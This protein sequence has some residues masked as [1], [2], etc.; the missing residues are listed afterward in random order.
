MN[1]IKNLLKILPDKLYLQLMYF[2]HFRKFINFNN[3]KSFNEKI[4]YLKLKYR[5]NELTEMADKYKVKQYISQLIGN[6]YVIPTLGVWNTTEE[7][8]FNELPEKFVLKCNNDSGG[9]VICKDKQALNIEET[10]K[11]L[12][13]RLNNNGFWYGR[14]WPYKNIKPC[15]IAEKYMEN[16][17]QNELIDYKFFCFNGQPKVVLVCSERFASKNMCKTY[18]DENWNLLDITEANHR[19][20]KE[21]KKPQNFE[22][23]KTISQKLAKDMP[24]VRIDFYEI[25]GRLYFG[26][27]TFFPASGL[28]KFKPEKW[29]NIFGDMI[30]ISKYK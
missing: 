10:K 19:I 27:I 16:N 5:S 21:Q 11:F 4:Q 17:G 2:K 28:E 7:I 22:K 15:I 9:V 12:N 20:D 23:M 24:F 29:N 25:E 30:D 26:E 18:F 1:I 13:S 6:E 14:E 8:N 3:P